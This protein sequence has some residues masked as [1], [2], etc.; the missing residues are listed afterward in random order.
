MYWL[1]QFTVRSDDMLTVNRAEQYGIF[2]HSTWG[3]TTIY[4]SVT[5]RKIL[6]DRFVGKQGDEYDRYHIYYNWHNERY[7]KSIGCRLLN[8]KLTISTRVYNYTDNPNYS[9]IC[10]SITWNYTRVYLYTRLR[11]KNYK[12]IFQLGKPPTF[13]IY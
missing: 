5:N 4:N 7:T 9:L 6:I 8:N 3:M 13:S 12:I 1:A 11:N 2:E 10:R